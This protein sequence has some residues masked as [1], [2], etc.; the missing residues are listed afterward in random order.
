MSSS[1]PTP[2]ATPVDLE[3]TFFIVGAGRSGT[4]L[5]RR[6]LTQHP[7]LAVTPE[8]HFMKLAD[9]HA[10]LEERP[11]EDFEALW[12]HYIETTRFRDLDVD[13]ARCREL[14]EAQ[15]V[16]TGRTVFRAVLAAY[17]EKEGKRRVGE[18]T[19]R[20][21][22]WAGTLLEWFP[23]GRIIIIV[24]DP[25]AVV[26][27]KMKDPWSHRRAQGPEGDSVYLRSR[28]L[29]RAAVFAEEWMQSYAVN[30]RR[31]ADHPRVT[32]TSYKRLVV[33]P[34]AV[35][36]ELCA[37]LGEE[38]D[39][40]LLTGGAPDPAPPAGMVGD[41]ELDAWR[42]E[43]HARAAAPVD[44]NSLEKWKHQLR[45]AEIALVEGWCGEEMETR[46]Y[47][48]TSDAS[49]RDRA[50]HRARRLA[51]LAKGEARLVRLAAKGRQKAWR[52]LG[53]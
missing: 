11:I 18:K 12:T 28:R 21:L 37:F 38:F 26:A 3:R 25:R 17:G 6:L 35:L 4:T 52:L 46:G 50:C 23:E 5:L 15:G 24:R 30:A 9:R 40:S 48:L 34:E 19:P 51:A 14:I 49:D 42:K 10:L 33:E 16:P 53:R 22:A 39:P 43:H 20:H 47:A 32:S 31:W 27:S 41:A 29:Y 36:R 8:T 2:P 7:A 44:A 13:P 45:P 1:D